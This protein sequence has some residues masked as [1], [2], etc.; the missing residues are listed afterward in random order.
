MST[1]TLI[2][3]GIFPQERTSSK[4][5]IFKR[6][7][8]FV[9]KCIN[10][11][12]EFVRKIYLSIKE[13]LSPKESAEAAAELAIMQ[14]RK[15]CGEVL[16][17][18]NKTL[19]I[20]TIPGLSTYR[21]GSDKDNI[22]QDDI[23]LGAG[24]LKTL[25]NTLIVTCKRAF[26]AVAKRGDELISLDGTLEKG[27]HELVNK[28][29]KYTSSAKLSNDSKESTSDINHMKDLCTECIN[30]SKEILQI[31]NDDITTAYRR[32]ME[33]AKEAFGKDRVVHA[34]A[35]NAAR[36]IFK[37]NAGKIVGYCRNSVSSLKAFFNKID[38][39]ASSLEKTADYLER[40]SGII[41]KWVDS[42]TTLTR[43]MTAY[44]DN[45]Y[46]LSQIC[47]ATSAN[48]HKIVTS[49]GKSFHVVAK[50]K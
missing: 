24:I 36:E 47:M 12:K 43:D 45:V 46:K 25:F 6:I 22:T 38:K 17:E 23:D 11:I 5:S 3:D 26:E 27:E 34:G 10:A 28:L 21:E 33:S 4:T 29:N 44:S 14:Y 35:I 19:D 42:D 37:A 48:Y 20:S 8:N 13:I 50:S 30:K 39:R 2:Q 7:Y 9:L 1:E 15:I 31:Y 41:K 16:K 40:F 32:S 49:L 18:N